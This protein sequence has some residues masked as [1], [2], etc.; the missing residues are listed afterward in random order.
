MGEQKNP[1]FIVTDDVKKSTFGARYRVIKVLP[2]H[3]EDSTNEKYNNDTDDYK[4]EIEQ[5]TGEDADKKEIVA[6]SEIKKTFMQIGHVDAE[7]QK[8]QASYGQFA[9]G[10]RRKTM[11]K[12][13][14]MR[15]K[16]MKG[17][18]MRRKTMKKGRK[19]KR[20]TIKKNGK[21]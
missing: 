19:I 12:G 20:K 6:E 14:K 1:K 13:R 15:R 8:R 21:K 7:E 18:K 3:T 10:K 11:K 2:P 4:Y 9:G 17:R 5:Q 16:T